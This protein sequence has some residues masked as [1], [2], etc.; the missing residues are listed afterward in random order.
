[1]EVW[2]ARDA[3]VEAIHAARCG[4]PFAVLGPHLTSDGWV[5]RVFA[6]DALA[7]RA[8]TRDEKAARGAA[9]AQG[10]LLRGADSAGDGAA[11]LSRRGR[12]VV[13]RFVLHRLVCFRAG[14]RAGRRLPAARRVAPAT[15]P[16]S[17]R[18]A[19][20]PRGRRWR[21]VRALGAQRH[22]RFRGRRLQPLGRAALPDAQALRQR[23]MG[24]LRPPHRAGSR[25][26]VRARRA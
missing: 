11:A 2:R 3:D 19:H 20:H 21:A 24:D 23:P 9:A 14:A 1:M 25:L 13:R 17:R 7:V 10:R 16:P 4:D 12:D 15:L 18:A 22:P 6:P 26:Q 8:L 5:I